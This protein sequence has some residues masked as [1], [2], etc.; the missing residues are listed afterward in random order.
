MKRSNGIQAKNYLYIL[1]FHN[2]IK[3]ND[4]QIF[5][6]ILKTHNHGHLMGSR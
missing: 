3:F 1:K 6:V 5:K 4:V 2:F